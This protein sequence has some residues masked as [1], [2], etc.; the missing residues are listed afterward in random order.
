MRRRRE[1]SR[2]CIFFFF[3]LL[4]DYVPSLVRGG[5]GDEEE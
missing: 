2:G 3:L 4:A 1:I 5:D